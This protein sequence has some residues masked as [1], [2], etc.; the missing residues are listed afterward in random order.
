MRTVVLL[1]LAGLLCRSPPASAQRLPAIVTPDHYD[2]AFIVDLA[3]ERFEGTK[4]S[5]CK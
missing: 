2:L 3:R 4:R 1:A 5:K